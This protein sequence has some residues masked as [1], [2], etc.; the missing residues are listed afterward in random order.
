MPYTTHGTGYQ[1]NDTSARAALEVEPRAGTLRAE[2]IAVLRKQLRPVSTETIAALLGRPYGSIQPRL[3]ELRESG[4]AEDSGERGL[5]RW[6]RSCILWRA[7]ERK[8]A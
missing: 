5:T 1:G 2:V 7:T 4:L 3:S 8:D 6:G